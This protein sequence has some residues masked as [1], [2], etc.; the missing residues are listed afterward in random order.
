MSKI[1]QGDA[2]TVLRT[3]KSES[4]HMMLTSPPYFG[5]RNYK[6]DPL[7]WGGSENCQHEWIS[8]FC[9]KC[10]AWLGS[11]GNEPNPDLY[12]SNL[13]QIFRE[14]KRV[15]RP[16]GTVWLNIG[17]SYS[18]SGAGGGGNRKGNEYGQHDE[19]IGKRPLIP[20]GLKPKDL[21]GIPWRLAFALQ[22]DGW[23]LRSDIIWA[24][25]C[26]F[27][28]YVGNP[29]PESVQGSS[30]VRHRVKISKSE[31]A[32][33][34]SSHSLSQEGIS[35]PQGAREGVN[36]KDHGDEYID[37]PGC[38]K[39]SPN[40][41]YVLS[42]NA[43]RPTCAHEYIFLLTK[44]EKYFFDQE[45]VKEKSVRSFSGNKGR[46]EASERGMPDDHSHVASSFEWKGSTRNVRSVWTIPDELANLFW[47]WYDS[48]EEQFTDTWTIQTRGYRGAHFATFPV[49]LIEPIIKAGSSEKGCCSNCG[50]PW[51][52]VINRKEE[53]WDGS[54]YGEHAVNATGG[55]ISGG[56]KES[57]LGSSHGQLIA[58]YETLGWKPTC[59]CNVGDPV[60]CT[61]LD[62]FGG[63]GTSGVVATELGRKFILIEL[64]PD[65]IEMGKKRIAE[66]AMKKLGK[67]N[68]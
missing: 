6:T 62:I 28:P 5:L 30:W 29:M 14:V 15:L 11:L 13:V 60:P 58:K 49:S 51:V 33:P 52:R 26:S 1:L 53:D 8:N 27:G 10:G 41:G 57:T 44:R 40:D 64:N 7:V 19:M 55:A 34:E 37:C 25:G 32:K 24:K 23:W 18:G 16:E 59:Q 31:L 17:D 20:S 46:K 50:M 35:T 43:G 65:Y 67:G 45:A 56:T 22:A 39:C 3:L 61:I 42:W 2:L 21:T 36:F 12:V 38:P 48:Q 4:V 47:E 68:E 63:A 66:A 9:S 54:K